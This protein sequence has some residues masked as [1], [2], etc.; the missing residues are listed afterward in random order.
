MCWQLYALLAVLL[1]FLLII[2]SVNCTFND[3]EGSTIALPVDDLTWPQVTENVFLG[4]DQLR[5]VTPSDQ[6]IMQRRPLPL[7]G[8][9]KAHRT[10]D[11]GR[12]QQRQRSDIAQEEVFAS[13]SRF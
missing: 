9:S 4:I 1:P 5:L 7:A 12:A 11:A 3:I 8:N 6:E 10:L 2:Q 13:H